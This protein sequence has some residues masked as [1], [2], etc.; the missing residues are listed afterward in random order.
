VHLIVVR[1]LGL[2]KELALGSSFVLELLFKFMGQSFDLSL[3]C[4]VEMLDK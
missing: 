3:V 2:L 4:L 1:G